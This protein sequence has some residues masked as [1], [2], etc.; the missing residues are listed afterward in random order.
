[1]TTPRLTVDEVMKAFV[2]AGLGYL[3]VSEV[4]KAAQVTQSLCA[5][6]WGH[7]LEPRTADDDVALFEMLN[8]A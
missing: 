1:M 3:G 7:T 6:K 4:V 2:A 5:A 8:G